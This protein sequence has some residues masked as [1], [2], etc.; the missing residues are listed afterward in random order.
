MSDDKIIKICD[1]PGNTLL[2]MNGGC[3]ESPDGKK[4]VYA[5]KA[6]LSAP[7]T[8]IM[9]C[10]RDLTDHREVFKV[11]CGNHNGPSASF[12]DNSLIVFRGSEG[13]H[14]VFRVLDTDTGEVKY[15]I[16]AKEN[17]CAV[18]GKYPF[19]VLADMVGLNPDYP[20]IDRPGIYILDVFKGTIRCII[21]AAEIEKLVTDAGFT[22]NEH[23]A[24][25]SHVQL[26]PSATSLMMRI[27]VPECPVFGALGCV[28]LDTGKTHLIPDKPV[29]QLWFDDDTY[30]ATKQFCSYV[31]GNKHIEMETSYLARFTKDGEELEVLGGIANHMDGS[32]DRSLFVGDRC[33]PGFSTDVYLYTRGSKKPVATFKMP[34]NEDT[35]W[36]KKVHA[37]PS[38]SRDGRRVYFNRIREDGGCDAVFAD[39]EKY[40]RRKA[41]LVMEGGAMRGLFTCGVIDV[42]LENG[43]DF[44]SVVGVSA[45]ATF[46]LNYVSKQPGRALRYNKE[47]CA[48]KRYASLKSLLTTGDI[49][50]VKFCYD[51]LPFELDKWD[52]KAFYDN[53]AD[54]FCVVTDVNTGKPV[55]HKCCNR[56][57]TPKGQDIRWVRAS[58]SMPLVSRPV[59]IKGGLYLDGGMSDS[60]P[61]KFMEGQDCDKILVVETRPADYRKEPAK[62]MPIIRYLLSKYPKMVEA[63]KNRHIMYNE[64]KEYVAAREKAGK[65]FVIRPE[66]PLNIGATEK[67]PK[68][69]QRVYYLG[70][71]AALES[72]DALKSYLEDTKQ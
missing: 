5:Y 56:D 29:H 25:V 17:H 9:V 54:F 27:S 31:D 13:G 12:I 70:R 68:E 6:D 36:K 14:P 33:Y 7:E 21:E 60:I 64:Q 40:T 2:G 57:Y 47:Y 24:S 45:G 63:L 42:L 34:M 51:T 65:I 19:T 72:L 53:P 1:K 39:I 62:K 38:F 23:T 49:Y 43:I 37:N 18:N 3:P 15:R 11:N 20:E 66:E 59:G 46:G 71:K 30:M 4:L 8:S 52:A 44:D 67:D 35:V 41:G 16:V 61:L 10:N 22:A 50:N 32:P 69:L 28:D 55:Y 48:D 58:A 26:N